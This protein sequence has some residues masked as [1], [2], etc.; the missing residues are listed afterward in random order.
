MPHHRQHRD[1]DGQRERPP[2]ALLKITQFGVALFFE[3]RNNGFQRHSALGATARMILANFRVH[4][5]GVNRRTC[6]TCFRGGRGYHF[7]CRSGV[8]M[9]MVFVMFVMFHC[10]RPYST[11][12]LSP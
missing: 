7:R 2:K 8:T 12:D 1:D 4:R 10:H 6:H 5:A 11:L 3:F 9:G